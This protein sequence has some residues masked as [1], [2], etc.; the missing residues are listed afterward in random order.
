MPIQ[1]CVVID[2]FERLSRPVC[3]ELAYEAGRLEEF[4]ADGQLMSP[5]PGERARQRLL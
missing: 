1:G 3:R 4:L 2:P 5:R